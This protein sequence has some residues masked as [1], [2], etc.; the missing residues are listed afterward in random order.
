MRYDSRVDENQS[1]LIQAARDMGA[2]VLL[3]HRV[4]MGCPPDILIGYHG[5]DQLVEVKTVK[6]E[7]SDGQAK[8]IRE[9]NG[10]KVKVARTVH[11]IISIV[12]AMG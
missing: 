4:G 11:D 9:W 1:G 8:F 6:G 10:R 7:L 5:I 2:S 3:L 12:L